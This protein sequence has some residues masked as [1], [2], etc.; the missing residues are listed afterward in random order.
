MGAVTDYRLDP[1]RNVLNAVKISG[2]THTIPKVSPFTIRL[3][4]V[5]LKETPSS[6]SLTIGGNMASEVSAQPAAG[7][8]WP[9]YS[10]GADGDEN[11]NTGT[12]LF[13]AADA[14]K[15]VVVTYKGTGILVDKRILADTVG[16]WSPGTY[17]VIAP[18]WARQAIIT[19]CGAG[20]GG[21]GGYDGP[22]RKNDTNFYASGGGGGGAYVINRHRTV[23]PGASY[24]ITIGAGGKGGKKA[25]AGSAGGTTSFDSLQ[26]L[27]GGGGGS[28]TTSGGGP[29]GANGS[30][31][32]S[33]FFPPGTQSSVVGRGGPFGKGGV[34]GGNGGGYGAGGGAG[35]RNNVIGGAGS[36]GFLLIRWVG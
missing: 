32:T 17:T 12:I 33:L 5:P 29:P 20:G 30:G 10:T 35:N 28:G 22:F 19:G 1:F 21:G 25:T 6:I 16:F 18:L 13:N 24:T 34:N 8:F 4:E 27:A 7:Q 26:S 2:E 9:D 3:A 36:I 11:W 23:T 31:F 14:G 15:K